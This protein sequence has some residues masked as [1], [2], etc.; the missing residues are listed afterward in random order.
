MAGNDKYNLWKR[1]QLLGPVVRC[2]ALEFVVKTAARVMHCS[3]CLDS[4][5]V[6]M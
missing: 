4:N 3:R 1:R 2:G 6:D 5:G